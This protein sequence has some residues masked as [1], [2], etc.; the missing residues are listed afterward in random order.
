MLRSESATLF[1]FKLL[2]LEKKYAKYT[3]HLNFLMECQRRNVISKGFRVKKSANIGHVSKTFRDDW[4]KILDDCS[5][6][7]QSLLTSEIQVVLG[8]LRE[9]IQVLITNLT[10]GQLLTYMDKIRV[11]VEKVNTTMRDKQEHKLSVLGGT[12][13]LYECRVIKNW[14]EEGSSGGASE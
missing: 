10:Q 6:R 9:Q 4:D 2:N 7:L 13:V 8:S 14:S 12:N 3:N 1:V 11:I 5:H